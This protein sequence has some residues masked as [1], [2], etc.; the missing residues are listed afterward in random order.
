[1]PLRPPTPNMQGQE[2]VQWFQRVYDA[3][4][5]LE[6][7]VGSLPA[8]MSSHDSLTEN[9]G[10]GSHAQIDIHMADHSAHGTS[11][12]MVGK[13]DVQELTRKVIK[14]A[15]NTISG[16]RHGVET[17]QPAI[18]HGTSSPIVGESDTQTLA[19]KSMSA[20]DNTFTGFRHGTEVDEPVDAHG[21]AGE[22]VGTESVQTLT[23]KTM[24]RTVRTV[25]SPGL[26]QETDDLLRVFNSG[27]LLRLPLSATGRM[28]TVDN[29]SNGWITLQA[30]GGKRIQ[31]ET[32]QRIPRNSSADVVYNGVEWRFV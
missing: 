23:N 7:A 9:G 26:L 18:A 6:A 24:V 15:E 11:S 12:D 17:D 3:I 29:V 27:L 31:G 20:T 13:D 28:F 2:L 32:S 10:V 16:L 5:A 8:P 4:Q 14:A 1:M 22:I 21:V 19:N 30:D 25:S